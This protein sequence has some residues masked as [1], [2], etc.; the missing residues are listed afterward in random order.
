MKQL[1]T[2]S[3]IIS[4]FFFQFLPI[5]FRTNHENYLKNVLV[6]LEKIESASYFSDR[7]VFAPGDT[8]ASLSFKVY[9]KEYNNPMDT[10]IG[11]TY[12][13]FLGMDTTK[14]MFGYDGNMR[15]LALDEER[16]IVVDS[17]KSNPHSFRPLSPPF[18]NYAKS[19]IKYAIQTSDSIQTQ[20]IEEKDNIHFK[21]E[22][23]APGDV[24]F[25]G[26][27]YYIK[28][29]MDFGEQISRYDIWF[30]K[31]TNLPFKVKREMSH[32][33]SQQTCSEIKIGYKKMEVLDLKKYFPVNYQLHPAGKKLPGRT[34]KH[35]LL[36]K[37]APDWTLRSDIDEET[38]LKDIKSKV[39]LLQFTSTNCGPCKASIPFLTQLSND[40]NATAFN[41]TAIE[42]TARSTNA[43]RV[44]RERNQFD[45]PILLSTKPV[46]DSYGIKLFPVFMVL[47]ESRKVK[48][49][50]E[51]FKGGETDKKIRATIN[52]LL[53]D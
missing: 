40:Y 15:S 48:E 38:S 33:I 11:A 18:F 32:D 16:T 50:F 29:P 42:V 25:F 43:L 47:D 21:L 36:G 27:P 30:D 46:T 26:G 51:G 34:K 23:Y 45:F 24:E 19:I 31:T 14:F 2:Y 39:I 28:S 4:I 5:S 13:T 44:Y 7:E 9:T 6:E 17:F 37:V 3:L 8:A 35:E 53:K 52:E 10:F 1:Y 20:L 49:V 41:L 22:I 12:A